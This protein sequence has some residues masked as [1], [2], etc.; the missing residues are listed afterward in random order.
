[1]RWITFPQPDIMDKLLIEQVEILR[2]QMA[3]VSTFA[4]FKDTSREKAEE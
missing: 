4:A 3:N 2:Q 1:M